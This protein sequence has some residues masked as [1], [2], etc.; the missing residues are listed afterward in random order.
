[1][2]ECTRSNAARNPATTRDAVAETKRGE[3]SS[4]TY[5]SKEAVKFVS[6]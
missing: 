6:I 1:M 5:L 4:E 2:R 3:M